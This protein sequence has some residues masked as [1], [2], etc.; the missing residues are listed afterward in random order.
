MRVQ[1][2]F[3]G[4]QLKHKTHIS[5]RSRLSIHITTKKVGF[6]V[7]MKL[8]MKEKKRQTVYQTRKYC[9]YLT[10]IKFPIGG[11]NRFMKITINTACR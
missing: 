2:E 7:N 4:F 9:S 3:R 11:I 10:K 6:D 5:V 1:N 8:W